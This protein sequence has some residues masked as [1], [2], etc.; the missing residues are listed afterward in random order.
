[1]IDK[2]AMPRQVDS[3]TILHGRTLDRKEEPKY[4]LLQAILDVKGRPL[5]PWYSTRDFAELFGVSPRSIQ[6]RVSSGE[7]TPRNLP[8]GAKYLPQDIEAFLVASRK[9]SPRF[10]RLPS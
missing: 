6:N 9:V 4:P 7:L 3:A 1:M 2:N 10:K 5:Q 8:G